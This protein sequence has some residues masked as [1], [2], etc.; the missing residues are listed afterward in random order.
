MDI[1]RKLQ[2]SLAEDFEQFFDQAYRDLAVELAARDAKVKDLEKEIELSKNAQRNDAARIRELEH[3]IS[4]LQEDLRWQDIGPQDQRAVD[5]KLDE[6]QETYDPDRLIKSVHEA[7]PDNLDSNFRQALEQLECSYRALYE[8][9]RTLLKVT[10]SLRTQVKRHKDTVAQWQRWLSH[11]KSAT[12]VEGSADRNGRFDRTSKALRGPESLT[13]GK[14]A[15]SLLQGSASDVFPQ[16]VAEAPAQSSNSDT[17][18]SVPTVT[19]GEN[20]VRQ[21][22]SPSL[23]LQSDPIHSSPQ[24]KQEGDE[25]LGVVMLNA[26][27]SDP[28]S[29]QSEEPITGDDCQPHNAPSA[30]PT[31]VRVQSSKQNPEGIDAEDHAQVRPIKIKSEDLSSSPFQSTFQSRESNPSGTQDLDDVGSSVKT[32]KKQSFVV[33]EEPSSS[34]RQQVRFSRDQQGLRALQPKDNNKKSSD[35]AVL[36]SASKRRKVS[37]RGIA[38]IPAVTEDGEDENFDPPRKRKIEM[39]RDDLE[40]VPH[41]ASRNPMA[42]RRLDDLL[43]TPSLKRQLL[44]QGSAVSSRNR[45]DSGGS[46]SRKGRSERNPSSKSPCGFDGSSGLQ[47]PKSRITSNTDDF[48]P[49]NG[50]RP[51]DVFRGVPYRARPLEA[52]DLNCFKIN[53]E[54]NDGLDFAFNEVVRKQDRRK[55]LPGCMRA[56]CCGDKFRAMARASV[57]S[58]EVDRRILEEYLGD[59]KHVLDEL[60]DREREDLLVEAKAR[61]LADRYGRHRYAHERPRSPPGFW[62]TDMPSTQEL[63]RDREEAKALEREKIKERYREAMRPGGLWKFADE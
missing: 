35:H 1:F 47:V 39:S 5:E 30:A 34:P 29:T 58:A 45:S 31:V 52:L 8:D 42:H 10:G 36:Y 7:G 49:D 21:R 44:F 55:C 48:E 11:K 61:F 38:A 3:Q 53:T 22:R 6:L 37:E 41:S 17:D 33:F 20:A 24:V 12:P 46:G 23:P 14:L 18:S 26:P 62:R 60:S 27:G 43:E 50:E 28:L 51:E 2:A 25:Y 4:R 9:V 57:Q 16:G 54:R 40:R 59:Q 15:S 32:P 13:D 63:A 56:G 19:V